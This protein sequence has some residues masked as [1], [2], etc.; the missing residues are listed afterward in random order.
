MVITIMGIHMVNI[1]KNKY[2]LAPYS[3][4]SL[5]SIN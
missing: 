1:Q 4:R 2:N 3:L 5:I